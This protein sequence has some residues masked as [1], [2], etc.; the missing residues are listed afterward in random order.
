M[1]PDQTFR[2][3][4][5]AASTAGVALI[6]FLR[7][8]GSVSLPPKSS[9]PAAPTGTARQ[10]VTRASA[11]TP[12]YEQY[13]R[14]DAETAMVNVPTL[15]EMARKLPSRLDDSTHVLQ[16]G[17]PIEIVGLRL[18][19]DATAD[20]LTLRIDNLSSSPV[21]YRVDTDPGIGNECNSARPLPF[22]AM[23]IEKGGS[24]TRVECIKRADVTLRV[25]HAEAID[26]N[27]LEAYYVDHVSPIMLG[28][29]DRI[30]R[31]HSSTGQMC[32][33]SVSQSVRSGIEN[34]EISWRDLVDFYARH[35]CARYHFPTSYRAFKDDGERALPAVD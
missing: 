3:G 33:A 1:I 26:L 23:V 5:L 8:C 4:V 21:A 2:I 35:S 7:F 28:L 18:R 29:E 6:G 22:D 10:L 25:R 27:P 24:E 31:G 32:S 34:K 11:Q 16:I 9:P 17:T 15:D 13:L 20:T 19:L 30:T 12:M 14:E